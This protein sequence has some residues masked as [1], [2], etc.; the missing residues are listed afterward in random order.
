MNG[1][2]THKGDAH[3][4]VPDVK[5]LPSSDYRYGTFF[6]YGSDFQTLLVGPPFV[7]R[8]RG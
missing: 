3:L 7:R 6:N 4:Q 8:R 2:M 1:S 5:A